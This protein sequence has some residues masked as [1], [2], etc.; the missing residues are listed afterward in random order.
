M[1]LGGGAVTGSALAIGRP[2]AVTSQL[3]DADTSHHVCVRDRADSLVVCLSY[4]W[5]HYAHAAAD[6][7]RMQSVSAG[8]P[9]W[10][11]VQ[12]LL[13]HMGLHATVSTVLCASLFRTNAGT[14]ADHHAHTDPDH[15]RMQ[16]VRTQ[17]PF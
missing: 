17:L 13:R 15:Q 1:T 10:K 3:T 4:A 8:L 11:T 12:L 14:N 7:R 9:G 2:V 5:G 16:P 6:R